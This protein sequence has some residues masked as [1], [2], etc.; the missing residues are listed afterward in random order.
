[1]DYDKIG[2]FITTLRKE[3][4]LTQAKLAEKIFVS[5]KT[6]SKWENGKSLP[7]TATLPL[8]CEVLQVSIN[9]LLNGEKIKKENYT[10]KAEEKLLEMRKQKENSDKHLLAMEIVIGFLSVSFLLALTFIA[11]YIEMP[12]YLQVILIVMGLVVCIIGILFALKIEQ[13]AGYYQCKH[14]A[15]KHIPSFRQVSFS[16]HVNRTRFLKCPNCGKK[17]WQKKVIK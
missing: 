16:M 2:V 3:K 6:I 5:E 14:C 10:Q 8:L 17:S 11:S 9:E 7:D 13:V 1:M 15:H 4:N 12:E